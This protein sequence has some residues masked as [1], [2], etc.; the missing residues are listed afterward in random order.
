MEND[1]DNMLNPNASYNDLEGKAQLS[2]DIDESMG[3]E[4]VAKKCNID[5]SR[6][7]AIGLS[8]GFHQESFYLNLMLADRQPLPNGKRKVNSV[9][10]DISYEDFF[11][12]VK[13][14]DVNLFERFVNHRELYQ[15]GGEEDIDNVT[16]VS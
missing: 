14:L 12:L 11:G 1:I 16:I 15:Y 10:T 9:L 7:E 4:T 6:Y 2:W 5:T 3:L 8:L 13:E